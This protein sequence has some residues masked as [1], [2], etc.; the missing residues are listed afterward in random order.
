[1]LNTSSLYQSLLADDNHYFVAKLDV[2]GVGTFNEDTIFELTTGTE[3]FNGAPEVGGA[4]A[5]EIDVKLLNNGYAEQIS[6]D[7]IVDPDMTLVNDYIVFGENVTLENDYIRFIST[8]IDIPK[9]A[10]LKPYVK[11]CGYVQTPTTVTV[12][13]PVLETQN[14][15]VSGNTLT[16]TS[17]SQATVTGVTINFPVSS[18]L[19]Y[20][21]S[22]WVPQGVYYIDTREVTKNED[23][24][25]VLTI[26]GY[27]A[28]LKTE[29]MF[30]STGI[31]GDSFDT[32][33]V[34][35]IALMIGTDVDS[36]TFALMTGNYIIPL[37]VSFTY[38]EILGYIASMYFGT[39]IITEEGKLRLISLLELPQETSYLIDNIGNAITFGADRIKV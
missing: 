25:D 29:Q 21:E 18:E 3:L 4:I 28:M 26:H 31:V 24:L 11:V 35:E 36:R 20:A 5:G 9:M 16:F 22:E 15:S 10:C 12:N 27:D 1:M 30:Q 8:V 6:G 17:A 34:S 19:S 23:G 39:F 14:A 38:R 33:M 32:Q 2:D 13:D 7:M 37:P